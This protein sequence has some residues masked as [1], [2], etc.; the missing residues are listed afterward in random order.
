MGNSATSLL[1]GCYQ[2]STDSL[3]Q[4]SV[5]PIR[6]DVIFGSPNLD[7]R[8]TGI[9]KI[10]DHAGAQMPVGQDCRRAPAL[11]SAINGGSVVC[12]RM[13]REQV[14][15]NVYKNHLRKGVLELQEPCAMPATLANRIG[16]A[17]NRLG[18]GRFLVSESENGITIRIP[19]QAG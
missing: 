12:I 7:C 4:T 1:P 8:G 16:L 13:F 11:L 19:V 14:C 5:L 18:P 17:G 10:M 3:V 9:C 15:L 2:P 6:C